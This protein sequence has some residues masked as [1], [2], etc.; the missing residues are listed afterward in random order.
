MPSLK[1]TGV[2]IDKLVRAA[3][4][5]TN[6]LTTLLSTIEEERNFTSMPGYIASPT[7]KPP[8]LPELPQMN[9]LGLNFPVMD[10]SSFKKPLNEHHDST[11]QTE[12]DTTPPEVPTPELSVIINTTEDD[13]VD[14]T[15]WL[16]EDTTSSPLVSPTSKLDPYAV[17]F[18]FG[19]EPGHGPQ[20]SLVKDLSPVS[21][22][23][24]AWDW[25][26]GDI[27]IALGS[28]TKPIFE[29]SWDEPMGG[30]MDDEHTL[31]ERELAMVDRR[32]SV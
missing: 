5:R 26:A 17:P 1:K 24:N 13:D 18:D 30:D 27:G 9:G 29:D 6:Q 11:G 3:E 10:F 19:I 25:T 14:M 2:Y 31:W 12:T 32:L 21:P 16:S 28:P 7:G 15:D 23:R 22:R 4:K 8:K 20:A